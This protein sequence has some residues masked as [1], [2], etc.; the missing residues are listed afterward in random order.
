VLREAGMTADEAFQA[1][2]AWNETNCD[3]KWSD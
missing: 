3:P 2:V 1:L